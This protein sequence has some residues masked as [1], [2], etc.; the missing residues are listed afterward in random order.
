M[1]KT[2]F[3]LLVIGLY[4]LGCSGKAT[5]ENYKD[6][7]IKEAKELPAGSLKLIAI[8]Y[9]KTNNLPADTNNDF[10]SCLG[11]MVYAKAD[12]L[13]IGKMLEWCKIDYDQ[14]KLSEHYNTADLLSD[15][16]PYDGSHRK[17]EKI[18]KKQVSNYSHQKTTYRLVYHGTPRPYMLVRTTFKATNQFGALV[19][20]TMNAKFDAKTKELFELK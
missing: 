2:V 4:F 10:Y 15:F 16:S 6:T 14:G 9:V 19:T 13:T 7:T 5:Y 1:K 8:D 20:L 12:N 17:L 11:E 3:G 18:I